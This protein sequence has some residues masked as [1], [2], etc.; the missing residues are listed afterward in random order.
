MKLTI[1]E[2]LEDGLWHVQGELPDGE[3]RQ[4]FYAQDAD[5][6]LAEARVINMARSYR[7]FKV[8]L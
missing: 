4:F 7:S 1:S 6:E 2:H 5:R 8:E 3:A